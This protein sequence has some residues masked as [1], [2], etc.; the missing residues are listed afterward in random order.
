MSTKRPYLHT[1]RTTLDPFQV[2][3]AIGPL[4][5]R[6]LLDSSKKDS[7]Y[8]SYSYIGVEPF[9]LLRSEKGS[10]SIR[11]LRKDPSSWEDLSDQNFYAYLKDTLKQFP[12]VNE[13]DLPFIG[14]ALGYFSYDVPDAY[15][16]FYDTILAYDH[17]KDQ[18]RFCSMEI[19][20]GARE[21]IHSYVEKI[22]TYA[23][24]RWTYPPQKGI[25]QK[26]VHMTSP[27]TKEEYMK[28][29]D[30]M[31]EYIAAGHIYIANMTHTFRGEVYDSPL[32]YYQNLR[33]LNPAP[34]SAYMPL[35][36]FSLL[37]S[38]PERF[39]RLSKG[40]VE[41]RPIK[42]TRPRSHDPIFN[43]AMKNELLASEKDKSELLMIVDLERNDLSRV[44][45]N[46]SV[47]VPELFS[48]EEYASVYHLVATVTGELDDEYDAVDLLEASFP[49][50]SITGAPKI[51]AME[52]IDELERSKRGPYTGSLG[53]IGFDGD[54]DLNI[55]IRSILIKENTAY[56]GV[57]GGI[58][59]ESEPEA[60]YKETLAKAKL[61]F[62]ALNHHVPALSD[63]HFGKGILPPEIDKG[64]GTVLQVDDGI[65][66]GLSFFETILL[67]KQPIFLEAH[68]KR[69]NASLRAFD[70][71][72]YIPASLITDIVSTW[73][74]ENMALKIMVSRENIL[75]SI[76]PLTYTPEYYERGAKI[77]LSDLIRSSRSKLVPH[78]SANYGELILA[79]REAHKEGLDDVLF[80][81]EEGHLCESAIC[82]LFLIKDGQLFTPHLDC[83]LLPGILRAY[84]IEHF[85]VQEAKLTPL[86][87]QH[88]DGAFL[89]NSLVG[90]INLSELQIGRRNYRLPIHPLQEEIALHYQRTLSSLSGINKKE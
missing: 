80:C 90:I 34:F 12:I 49:G 76:R 27:F 29:I 77:K 39:L 62:S 4:Q 82:N 20:P 11:D 21:R 64:R 42:G 14:G 59:C 3:Q 52:I 7:P 88:S 32:H 40:K 67:R 24:E 84:V 61:L 25:S 41:T 58:T 50:G 65:S 89:T 8:S 18:Y 35:E 53:F 60:E 26:P 2:Y 6:I 30:A 15:L 47:E 37:C 68:L 13:T 54:M 69:L 75:I 63:L 74:L 48:L 51:R 19:F 87:L 85:P 45:K 56:I 43:E 83:G 33:E 70:I 55:I 38:S 16:V 73:K 22:H 36:G 23:Q 86:D 66:F 17:K 81:N 72:T 9:L 79:L 5:D 46:H 57:G 28:Q 10:C 78:K 31:K 44:C 1:F 71:P